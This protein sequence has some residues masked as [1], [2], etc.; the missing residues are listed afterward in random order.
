MT[1]NFVAEALRTGGAIAPAVIDAWAADQTERAEK[2][3]LFRD[4]TAGDHPQDLTDGMRRL[5][6][7]KAGSPL[8]E[9]ALNYMD[10]VVQT[11]ADRLR[12]ADITA[13]EPAAAAWAADR[14]AD[15][16]FDSLQGDVHESA[17]TDGDTYLIAYF[18][19]ESGTVKWC[20]EPAFDGANG[21][22]TVYATATAAEPSV[23]I[24]VWTIADET[25][26]NVYTADQ[27]E[28]YRVIDGKLTL[29]ETA[30][31]A[32]VTPFVGRDGMPIGLPVIHFRNRARR[33]GAY[34]SSEI[35]TA[36]PVQ[37]ALNRTLYSMI[38]AAELTAFQIRYAVGWQPPPDLS[39]GMW[40]AI[41]PNRP[42]APDEKIDI[43]T[44]PQGELMP[45]LDMARY[46]S[47][48]IGK[49]TRTPSPEFGWEGAS[50]ES[51]KQREIGLIGK[52]RRFQIKAGEAWSRAFAIGARIEAAYGA[53][54]PPVGARFKV[55]WMPV[56]VRE[57]P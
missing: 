32:G 19:P 36:I 14:M 38:M 37:N 54:S 16:R 41:S 53:G 4:Y 9:F 56:D 28:R 47:T 57:E 7:I 51:L 43:G 1:L 24:K 12:V 25:R 46:L 44:M 52:A 48:E 6:R 26:I 40:L 17:L 5:L 10:I 15:S 49:I 22:L 23:A 29:Y 45:Y 11:L 55:R 2:V 35:E 20:H 50:G 27:I 13:D 3:A 31:Q 30:D 34:G 39:P 21:M 42:L 18:D 33:W 8:R